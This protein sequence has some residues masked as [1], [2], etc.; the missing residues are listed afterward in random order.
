MSCEFCGFFRN[1]Y[2]EKHLR[3]A[4]LEYFCHVPAARYILKA[5][6]RTLETIRNMLKVN[7]K[8]TQNDFNDVVQV[9][10]LVTLN[11]FHTFFQGFYCLKR[12]GNCQLVVLDYFDLVRQRKV[13]GGVAK[14]NEPANCD[15]K[16]NVCMNT[17]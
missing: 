16:L 4:L 14:L 7:N 15:T 13:I 1:I 12:A 6:K 3:I 11:I 2:F 9:S 8:V 5:K 10:L 17:A